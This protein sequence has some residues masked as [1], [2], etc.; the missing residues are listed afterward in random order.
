M[1]SVYYRCDPL[2]S[3]VLPWYNRY[4]F[5]P[6]WQ[7][8]WDMRLARDH[9]PADDWR[10]TAERRRI[11][12]SDS[13]LLCVHLGLLLGVTLYCSFIEYISDNISI[14]TVTTKDYHCRDWDRLKFCT[15]TTVV[16]ENNRRKEKETNIYWIYISS[17]IFPWREWQISLRSVCW[18]SGET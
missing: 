6:E 18:S 13:S 10:R 16:K 8:H 1:R 2:Y 9:L 15:V 4:Y 12:F 5:I 14:V 11:S 17:N 3:L 7:R